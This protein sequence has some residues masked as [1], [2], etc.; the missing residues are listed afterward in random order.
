[1]APIIEEVESLPGLQAKLVTMALT[2]LSSRSL[3]WCAS[4]GGG[5]VWGFSVAHPDPW[6]LVAATAYCLTVLLPILIRD[7]KGA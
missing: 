1:M 7:A 6:R 5:V 4:I 2:A 3:V